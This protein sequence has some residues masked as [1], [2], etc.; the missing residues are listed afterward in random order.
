MFI[1]SV[2]IKVKAGDGGRGCVSRYQDGWNMRGFA[3]GG[4]GGHGA[5][6]IIRTD[7]NLHTLMDLQYHRHFIGKHGGHGSS[8]Q[9]RGRNADPVIIR[10]PQGT[11]IIDASSDCV[12]GKLDADQSEL[13][14]A[15]GGRGGLGNRK[16][17]DPVA[18]TPG[19]EKEL[20]IDLKLIA[21]VGLVGFPNA[22]KSTLLSNVSN[23]N[24]RIASYPFTTKFPILGVAG[25]M[26]ETFVIADIPGLIEGSSD[27]RGLG[28][29][30]L[31]HVERTKIL[32]HVVDMAGVDGRDPIQ[33][34]K[35]I[36]KE[37]K[38]YDLAVYKKPQLIVANKMDVPAAAENLV[39]FK[40]AVRKKVYAVSA[41][42]KEGL[43]ELVGA[44]WKKLSKAGR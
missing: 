1:D 20:L 30:F 15:H 22:G 43:D 12:L 33:D 10:V 36:N 8:K 29:K 34:Y 27:G 24:P 32:V 2:R 16:N 25:E 5:D 11:T 23:A 41:L 31:R 21:D 35:N 40:A 38:G 44:I 26:D 7:R 37:L 3:D 9:Q 18:P 42:R 19:E 28:D 14:V 4:D 13:I 17:K 6:I 39:R